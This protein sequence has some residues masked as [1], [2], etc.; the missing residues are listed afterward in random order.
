M[1]QLTTDQILENIKVAMTAELKAMTE[2]NRVKTAAKMVAWL[3][4]MKAITG[5]CEEKTE[6]FLEKKESALEPREVVAESQGVPEG[7]TDQE[8]IGIT[9]DRYGDQRLA[10]RR[11]RQRKRRAQIEVSPG[12]SLL[13]SADGL[14]AVLFLQCARGISTGDRV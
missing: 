5:I 14:P 7:A 13:P 12:R 3:R 2:V 1:E 10:V 6:A 9:E 8:T 4:E 11:R